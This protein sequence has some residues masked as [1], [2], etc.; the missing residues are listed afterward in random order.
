MLTDKMTSSSR[1]CH[2]LVVGTI[3]LISS[4][5]SSDVFGQKYYPDHPEVKRVADLAAESLRGVAGGDVDA[6]AG[7]AVLQHAKRYRQ[8]VPK[9]DPYL[10]AVASRI[11]KDFPADPKDDATRSDTVVNKKELYYPCLAL[12][13]LAEYDARKY[14]PYIIRLLDMLARRQAP[15][16]SF[17][18]LKQQRSADTSQTQYAALAM[19]VA[20]QHNISYDPM[21]A[22]RTLNW[23]C[24][25]RLQ[26]GTWRY[27][28]SHDGTA[29]DAGHVSGSGPP[30]LSIQA[31][32]ASSVYLLAD[33]L[34]LSKR[35]KSM[36]NQLQQDFGLPPTVTPYIKP[37]EGSKKNEFDKKGP[38][39]KFPKAKIS[40]ATTGANAFFEK[41][42]TADITSWC[43]YYL[44]A[45]E[46][47]AYFR[48][49][50]EGHLGKGR[51]ESWYDDAFLFFK[52]LQNEKGYIHREGNESRSISTAFALLVLVRSSEV[53]VTPV[54]GT[55]MLGGEGLKSNV[56]IRKVQGGGIK[57]VEAEKNLEDLLE[58][59]KSKKISQDQLRELTESL[60][61]QITEFRKKDDKS[62]R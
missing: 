51:V 3:L 35:S 11:I 2:F 60:K 9:D 43:F 38:L 10:E 33:L 28:L 5:F 16:G 12:I 40:G 27:M 55:E 6:L 31:A 44:Y 52:G 39:V 34:N 30:T 15:N 7:L 21:M 18:Y 58:M 56:V 20:K 46:R 54:A 47:Y 48:E 53:I 24:D 25:S 4:I 8:L 37:M 36:A 13:Y 17:T 50:A 22:A 42:F 29:G 32:A 49:Q 45:F 41:N 26:D 14:E 19:F 59:M 62:R 61:K 1:V 23:L 57:A